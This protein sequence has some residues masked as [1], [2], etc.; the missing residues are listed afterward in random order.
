M[1]T[2][3]IK[4]EST[5]YDTSELFKVF[6]DYSRVKILFTLLDNELSVNEITAIL[7][8]NQSAVSHQLS[9][10]KKSKLIKARKEGKYVFYSLADKHVYNILAQGIEHTE[11]NKSR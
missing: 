9:I 1:K 3:N 2:L 10:L 8:M 7:E 5:L 11:E 6:S 4:T